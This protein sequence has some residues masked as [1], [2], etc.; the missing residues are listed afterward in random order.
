[1]KPTPSSTTA[2]LDPDTESVEPYEKGKSCGVDPLQRNP[3]RAHVTAKL[4]IVC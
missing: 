4:K 3:K 1:M 2:K